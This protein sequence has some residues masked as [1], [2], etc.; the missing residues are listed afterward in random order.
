MK[1]KILI[2]GVSGYIGSCLYFYLNRKFKISGIDKINTELLPVKKYNLLNFKKLDYILKKEKP[3]LIIHLAAQSLVDETINKKKYFSNNVIAT[4]NLIY[5]MKKNNLNNIIFSSTAALYKFKNKILTENSK[6]SPKSTYAKTKYEC[7]KIIKDSK[8]NSVILRFFNVCSSLKIRNRIIGEFHNPE[9]HLIPTI[10]Y[11]NLCKQKIYIY[12]NNYKT[13]DGTCVRDYIHINDICRAIFN[14]IKF[15][16]RN[17][18]C[19][20]IINIGSS[21]KQTNLEIL[22]R[23]K[24]ITK[25]DNKYEVVKR[26]TGDVDFLTCSTRKA[27]IKLKWKPI[28]SNIDKIIK[29]EINWVKYLL[30]NKKFRKFK[31]YL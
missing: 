17:K 22:N 5:A 26:R 7:E 23:I 30:K 20:E 2:T 14:S 3:N 28:F 11:K 19:F 12:G 9:T 8:L 4:R 1:M 31:N 25:I 15:L 6:I 10:V 16:T 29:D 21:S 24:D 13:K 27:K 18:N